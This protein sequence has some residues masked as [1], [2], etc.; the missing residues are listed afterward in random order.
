MDEALGCDR[1]SLGRSNGH[2]ELALEIAKLLIARGDHAGATSLLDR[3]AADDETRVAA[4]LYLA[5]CAPARGSHAQARE[6]GLAAHLAAPA[7]PLVLKRRAVFAQAAGDAA[8]A[9]RLL[10][11]HGDLARRS[12]DLVARLA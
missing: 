12:A 10:A 2:P 8:E 6:H 7:W 9:R 4:W 1:K 5:E 3:A 11:Q